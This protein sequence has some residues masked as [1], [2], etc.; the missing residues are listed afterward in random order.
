M[1]WRIPE[2]L[3]VRSQHGSADKAI[4]PFSICSISSSELKLGK[5]EVLFTEGCAAD[6]VYVVKSGLCFSYRNLE[7]GRRQIIDLAFPGDFAGLEALTQSSF[8]SGFAALTAAQLVAYPV[9]DFT[10][11][12]YAEPALSRTLVECIAREQSILTKRLVGVAHTSASQRIAHFLLEVRVRALTSLK[13]Q[14]L[15]NGDA[16]HFLA[17][18]TGD[19][20]LKLPQAVIADTLGLSIVHVSRTLSKLKEEGLIDQ[21]STGMRYRDLEGLKTIAVW[22]G[23]APWFEEAS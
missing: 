5:D 9:A 3:K 14:P 23:L 15:K 22:E 18:D 4:D 20:H 19:F 6:H 17:P 13:L 11:R 21:S 2:S 12:C 8:V 1:G 10:E 16:C 7:D